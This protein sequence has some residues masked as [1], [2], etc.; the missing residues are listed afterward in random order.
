MKQRFEVFPSFI[1]QLQFIVVPWA[2]ETTAEFGRILLEWYFTLIH[3]AE[4]RALALIVLVQIAARCR[5]DPMLHP[6]R[7][8][9]S[10]GVP[11]LV[12]PPESETAASNLLRAIIVVAAVITVMFQNGDTVA[13]WEIVEGFK[14]HPFIAVIIKRQSSGALGRGAFDLTLRVLDAQGNFFLGQKL[15]FKNFCYIER[16]AIPVLGIGVYFLHFLH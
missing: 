4:E 1:K 10:H 13:D 11:P 7:R 3:R 8:P 5:V 16:G 6:F 2:R 9:G 14:A 15:T 12:A